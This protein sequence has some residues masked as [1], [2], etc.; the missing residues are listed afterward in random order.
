MPRGYDCILLFNAIGSDRALRRLSAAER[1]A[2]ITGV[3]PLCAESPEW[4]W[5]LVADGVS[6]T[7]QDVAETA[8][9]TEAEAESAL[10][11][12][13]ELRI[14]ETVDGVDHPVSWEKYQRRPRA[15]DAPEATRE[16]KR[17]QRER[18]RTADGQLAID[19]P[20][21][22]A[23]DRPD[24]TRLCA[25]LA[26]L[27]RDRDPKAQ[28]KHDSP[29]WRDACRLLV[30]KDGRTTEEIETVMR[31]AHHDE[32][33]AA[34]VLS[35]RSLRAKFSQLTIKM[36]AAGIREAKETLAACPNGS[37][38]PAAIERWDAAQPTL[39]ADVADDMYALWLAPLHAHA[40]DGDTLVLGAPPQIR[41]Y[42]EERFARPIEKAAGQV[43][44]VA[45]GGQA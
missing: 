30:D 25:L 40:L 9:V 28:P 26:E 14:L 10:V 15:S 27:V 29:A 2:F 6:A 12:L 31:W 41:R 21:L 24:I 36:N 20:V 1:L 43:R 7:A 4:G 22:P 17:R 23:D 35:M 38:P 39:R 5:L 33:W 13:R 16:R 45:C 42:A 18:E 34:N 8:G 44:I 3:L 37:T 19:A 32:F 11:K